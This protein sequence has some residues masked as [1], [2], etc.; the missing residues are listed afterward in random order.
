MAGCCNMR[1]ARRLQGGIE[2]ASLT[3]VLQT[4]GLSQSKHYCRR[5]RRTYSSAPPSAA[6]RALTTI[7][8]QRFCCD[9]S[10]VCG[11]VCDSRETFPPK[12]NLAHASLVV[13]RDLRVSAHGFHRAGQNVMMSFE[14]LRATA[15]LRLSDAVAEQAIPPAE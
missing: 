6:R 14:S 1:R 15:K 11:L 8:C 12:T 7:Y 3:R 5:C 4:G 2:L 10:V 13:S 9:N